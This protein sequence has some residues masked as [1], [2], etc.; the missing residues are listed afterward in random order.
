MSIF[1]K[2]MRRAKVF[3]FLIEILNGARLVAIASPGKRAPLPT[4]A[5]IR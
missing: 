2:K 4:L 5:H 1:I 3:I